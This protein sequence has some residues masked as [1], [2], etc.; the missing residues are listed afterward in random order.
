MYVCVYSLIKIDISI[1]LVW[2]KRIKSNSKSA[3]QTIQYLHLTGFFNAFGLAWSSVNSSGVGWGRGGG[4][5]DSLA[6]QILGLRAPMGSCNWLWGWGKFY[7][8]NSQKPR[9]NEWWNKAFLAVLL[10]L[11]CGYHRSLSSEPLKSADC[12][13][14]HPGSDL[15]LRWYEL[16]CF[17]L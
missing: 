9:P 3:F 4:F 17:L 7:N 6:P 1:W 10:V 2:I 12:C 16:L 15:R 5:M 14:T 13:L 11:H 8:K